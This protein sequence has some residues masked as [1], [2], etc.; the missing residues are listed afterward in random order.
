M[1]TTLIEAYIFHKSLSYDS[2]KSTVSHNKHISHTNL[3]RVFTSLMSAVHRKSMILTCHQTYSL[4]INTTSQKVFL[5]NN[6]TNFTQ[7]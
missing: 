4:L 7:H 1:E 6:E 2:Y 5:W 3:H